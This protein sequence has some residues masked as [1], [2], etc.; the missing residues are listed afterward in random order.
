M[1]DLLPSPEAADDWW[2]VGTICFCVF[3]AIMVGAYII[4]CSESRR[5]RK[6][7]GRD[8]DDD[9]AGIA[10]LDSPVEA[11]TLGRTDPANVNSPDRSRGVGVQQWMGGTRSGHDGYVPVDRDDDRSDSDT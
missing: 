2:N 5:C 8:G 9:D 3:A 7:T 6:R 1:L 4:E 10:L 11:Y